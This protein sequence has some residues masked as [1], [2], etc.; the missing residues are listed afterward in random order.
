[1]ERT[2]VDLQQFQFLLERSL[3][4]FAENA[5]PGIV[6]QDVHV[7]VFAEFVQGERRLVLCQIQGDDLCVNGQ[8]L[9]HLEQGV[10]IAPRK[11]QRDACAMAFPIP[12]VAPVI[13][14]FISKFLSLSF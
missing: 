3:G 2:D 5:E 1:M 13:N 14:A 9:L 7:L 6:D 8:G 12:E 11:D 4:E 10:F